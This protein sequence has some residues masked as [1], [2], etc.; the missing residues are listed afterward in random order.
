MTSGV[1]LPY[2]LPSAAGWRT[3]DEA[4]Q[5]RL[6]GA[7]AG[8]RIVVEAPQLDGDQRWLVTHS[9][10]STTSTTATRLRYYESTETASQLLDGTDT[11]NF[12]VADWPAPGL[13]VPPGRSL[14]AVWSGASAGATAS[15]YLQLI[16]QA[17]S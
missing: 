4:V 17:R 13:L 12:D 11:G 15:L 9:V 1:Q 10:A 5:V 7:E 3:L 14:L 16:E 2:G 6:R 8:G